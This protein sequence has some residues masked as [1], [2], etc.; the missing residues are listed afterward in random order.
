MTTVA[1]VT[2]L[3]FHIITISFC[4]GNNYVPVAKQLWGLQYSIVGVNYRAV[5]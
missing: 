1:P 5:R 3:S 4:G 2:R